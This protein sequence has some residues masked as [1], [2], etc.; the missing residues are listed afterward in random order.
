MPDKALQ[1]NVESWKEKIRGHH[2][3]SGR[4]SHRH[5]GKGEWGGSQTGSWEK[6]NAKNLD[7]VTKKTVREKISGHQETGKS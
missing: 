1:A 5:W 6:K 4:N 7:R 2:R 3:C